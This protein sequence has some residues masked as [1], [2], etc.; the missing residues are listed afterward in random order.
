MLF[1]GGDGS[2]KGQ[3]HVLWSLCFRDR[4]GKRSSHSQVR[5]TCCSTGRPQLSSHSDSI[6]ESNEGR[7][8]VCTGKGATNSKFNSSFLLNVN[9]ISKLLFCESGSLS[10][11]PMRDESNFCAKSMTTVL[12]DMISE[13]L[14]WPVLQVWAEKS[15]TLP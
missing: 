8:C 12:V 4:W 6:F 1:S 10:K 7:C 13:D 3:W 2:D 5:T 11:I 9:F 14:Y 15:R